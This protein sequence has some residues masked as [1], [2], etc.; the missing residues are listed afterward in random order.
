MA[1]TAVDLMP[2]AT[3][4]DILQKFKV[5]IPRHT[6]GG[7]DAGRVTFHGSEHDGFEQSLLS[8]LRNTAASLLLLVQ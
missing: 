6:A 8:R 1:K 4:E 7:E 5:V 2:D 3:A